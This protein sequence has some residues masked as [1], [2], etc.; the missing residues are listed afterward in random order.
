MKILI[1]IYYFFR[2]VFL[3]GPFNTLRLLMAEADYEK[4]FGIKTAR[5]KTS[6]SKEFF[7]YQ[8]A[9]Y[10]VLLKLFK[11]ISKPTQGFNFVDIGCGKGRAIFVAEYCGYIELIGIEMDEELIAQANSNLNLYKFKRKE[12]SIVFIHSNALTYMYQ[13]KPTVYFLFNPFNEEVMGK[14][15]DK[16][17][18]ST[19]CETWFVYMNPLYKEAFK[20]R[21]IEQ[22]NEFKTGIYKEAIAYRIN[23]K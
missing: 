11:E 1:Y 3:R 5:I 16:I 8:G 22:V 15:L 23:G 10:L 21:K 14:V 9:S 7:H 2:S 17:I 12:S 13:N 6:D 18:S 20:E 19:E 4:K